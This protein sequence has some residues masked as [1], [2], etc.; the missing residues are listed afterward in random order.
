VEV[1]HT[2]PAAFSLPAVGPVDDFSPPDEARQINQFIY[3]VVINI[4]II[5]DVAIKCA[6]R[7]VRAGPPHGCEGLRRTLCGEKGGGVESL[8]TRPL[9]PCYAT[10]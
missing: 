7:A 9:Q 8:H 6:R 10:G 3:L 2:G 1:G 4:V 5:S